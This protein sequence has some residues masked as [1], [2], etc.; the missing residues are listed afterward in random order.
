M[1]SSRLSHQ[2]ALGS[3]SQLRAHV[4]PTENYTLEEAFSISICASICVPTLSGINNATLID[5]NDSWT[6]PSLIKDK[7]RRNSESE[8]LC[9]GDVYNPSRWCF[10]VFLTANLF[11][12][13]QAGSLWMKVVL[14]AGSYELWRSNITV[15]FYFL[16][17]SLFHWIESQVWIVMKLI[18]KGR[19]SS[20]NVILHWSARTLKPL[21]GKEKII[22]MI[23]HINKEQPPI[24]RIS[25]ENIKR[26]WI[27]AGETFK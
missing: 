16:Y 8:A 3:A 4:H 7:H 18:V 22:I 13:C 10:S 23:S 17:Y 9:C 15:N 1:T 6:L 24:S 5:F 2:Q 21:I 26:V 12:S 14:S 19:Y 25:L 11:G 27:L 20:S